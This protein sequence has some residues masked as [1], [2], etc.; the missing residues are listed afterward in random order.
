MKWNIP[1]PASPKQEK[2]K[3]ASSFFLSPQSQMPCREQGCRK[4]EA[5]RDD[6]KKTGGGVIIP[7]GSQLS[8][9]SHKSTNGRWTGPLQ[10][11]AQGGNYPTT[12]Q[13]KAT[14]P[15]TQL[16]VTTP[17]TQVESILPLALQVDIPS[18]CRVITILGSLFLE[19]QA[20]TQ[21]GFGARVSTG[22]EPRNGCFGDG[23][24]K[25]HVRNWH[26]ISSGS[27]LMKKHWEI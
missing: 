15:T 5:P 1:H 10:L 20:L 16:P 24:P 9:W 3:Q 21:Q 17:T 13:S 12:T 14:Y 19:I 25:S 2:K 11:G 8:Y 27:S 22:L 18:I 7:I 23:I 4:R 26:Q 6:K